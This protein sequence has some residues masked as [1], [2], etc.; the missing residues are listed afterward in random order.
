MNS[1]STTGK[2][3]AILLLLL[4]VL[5]GCLSG[6]KDYAGDISKYDFK[7]GDIML[8]HIPSYL[9]S[10]IADVTNSRYSHCGLITYKHGE[11]CVLEAIGPVKYT[12][13]KE[14]INRGAYGR[15]TQLRP[16]INSRAMI[17]N[18]IIEAEK[19]LG[20]PY[21]IQYEM[22]DDKIYCSELVY[23][24][25]LQ[26]CNIKIG[27]IQ[28]LGSLNWRPNEKFIRYITG[29]KLPLN[30]RMVTPVALERSPNSF[31]VYS[32]FPPAKSDRKYDKSILV[33]IWQGEYTIEGLDTAT[34]FLEIEPDPETDP[35][36]FEVILKEGNLKMPGGTEV[37]INSF[38]VLQAPK[39]N[40]FRATLTDS[41]GIKAVLSAHIRDNG[42]RLI[43]MWSDNKGYTGIFSLGRVPE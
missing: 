18:A 34:V 21:D 13:V 40:R 10:V 8:Q 23:K 20:K 35:P 32:T 37:L 29:G 38:K 22:G 25:Y 24:S 12:P 11:L 1:K 27:K 14:W 36:G 30:R 42:D 41:R 19:H 26:A 15:F 43:G 31:L 9:C 2:K 17:A 7:E 3:T 6:K 28:T 4:L 39:S 5:T 33:G 16:K